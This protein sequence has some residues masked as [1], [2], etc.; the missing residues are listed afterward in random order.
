MVY[1]IRYEISGRS[2]SAFVRADSD[3]EALS[4][5]REEWS[6]YG[7]EPPLAP[8]IVARWTVGLGRPPP[9]GARRGS[10]PRRGLW[11]RHVGGPGQRARL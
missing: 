10:T 9:R 6:E 1:E 7:D 8:W 3:E 5:F 4:T 2:G 11:A